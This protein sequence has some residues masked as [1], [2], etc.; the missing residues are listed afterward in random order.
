[1]SFTHLANFHLL[2]SSLAMLSLISTMPISCPFSPFNSTLAICFLCSY[3][4]TK[5]SL[6]HFINQ[7]C[8][9]ILHGLSPPLRPLTLFI[10]PPPGRCLLHCLSLELNSLLMHMA[11]KFVQ[12]TPSY[13]ESHSSPFESNTML[14]L[15]QLLILYNTSSSH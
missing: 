5:S 7:M 14:G 3:A 13:G 6:N 9:F 8:T 15:P 12:I 1:M 11:Y 4:N 10:L 2:T